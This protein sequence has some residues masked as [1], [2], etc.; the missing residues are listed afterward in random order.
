MSG[1]PES[2]SLGSLLAQVCRLHH[3]RA[4][5]LFEAIGLYRGQP[6]LL[7][8]LEKQEGLTHSDLAARLYVTP[9]TISK[10]VQR[11]E[12]AGFVVRRPDPA[13]Q[14]VSRVYLTEA[15]HGIRSEMHRMLATLEEEAFAR[16]GPEERALLRAFFVRIRVNLMRASEEGRS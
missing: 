11:M 14:R 7:F 4:H 2:E 13:D 6:P 15:G 12:R 1:S 5:T 9:A 10:M 8:A 3:A 16:L